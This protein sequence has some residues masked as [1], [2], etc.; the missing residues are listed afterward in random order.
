M[1]THVMY[2]PSRRHEKEH[3]ILYVCKDYEE[4]KRLKRESEYSWSDIGLI[5]LVI[6]VV[7]F[8]GLIVAVFI[9]RLTER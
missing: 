3:Q 9:A 1:P 2:M 6:S 4:Y 8:I 7:L 5:I